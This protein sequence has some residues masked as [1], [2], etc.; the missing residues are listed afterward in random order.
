MILL[1][2]PV[3]WFS[4]ARTVAGATIDLHVQGGRWVVLAFLGAA[5]NPQTGE[6]L[7]AIL[8]RAPSFAEDRLVVYGILPAPRTDAS[9]FVQISNPAL[10][11]IEDFDGTIAGRFGAAGSPRTI[12]LD[13]M[14]RAVANI[15]WDEAAGHGAVLG[16]VLEGLPD[17]ALSAGVPLYAPVLIVPRVFEFSLCDFLVELYQSQGGAESG[18]LMTRDGQT[19]TIVD[20]RFKRRQDLVIGHPE[21]KAAMRDRVQRRVVPAIERFFQYRPTRM[22]RYLV[23]CYDSDGGGYF[24]RHRDN[25]L[26]GSRHRRFA[27]TINLN[28]GYEGCDLIFPEFGPRTY[29]APVG[30][31]VVFSTGALHQVTPIT[32]GRRFAFVPFLYGDEDVALRI[33]DNEHLAA[34]SARYDTGDDLL[35]PDNV[36]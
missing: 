36:A 14:L 30:G 22:D 5:D 32:A 3:P 21:V 20:H 2:D 23:S 28:D 6:E 4:G 25:L 31:A 29:R 7:A 19:A 27:M 8:D 15:P 9:V 12:V 10:Q 33:E 34:G 18:F 11:F 16:R 13:P 17:V 35:V 24:Y 26:P 1:G